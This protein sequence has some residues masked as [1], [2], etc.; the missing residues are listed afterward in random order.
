MFNGVMSN[1]NNSSVVGG[2][3]GGGGAGIMS[4][5]SPV[6]NF[7]NFGRNNTSQMTQWANFTAE[8]V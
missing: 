4:S 6:Q 8:S 3:G 1:N 2:G 7:N 5:S